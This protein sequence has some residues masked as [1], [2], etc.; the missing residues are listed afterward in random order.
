MPMVPPIFALLAA[1]QIAA[2]APPAPTPKPTAA[3][4]AAAAPAEAWA[5]IDPNDLLLLD[6]ADG[7]RSVIWLAAE[8]APVHIPNI[9]TITR[10]GWW[11]DSTV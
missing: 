6:F 7:Q 9:R 11:S 1:A 8:F 5:G 2:S 4:L 10:S 3:Q